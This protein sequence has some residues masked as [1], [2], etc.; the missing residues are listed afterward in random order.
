MALILNRNFVCRWPRGC[1]LTIGNFD[2][3]HRGHQALLNHLR[4]ASAKRGLPVVA[5]LFEPQPNEW[6]T[7][8]SAP[9]R[10]TTLREKVN[11]LTR[12]GV[13]HVVCLRFNSRLA[14]LEATAFI[15]RLLIAQLN[16]KLLAIGDDFRFG[17]GRT[18]D[19]ALLQAASKIY[20]FSLLRTAAFC[21]DGQRISSTAVR[22]A[23]ADDNLVLAELLLGRPYSMSGRVIHGD[24][25]GRTLGFP[26]ANFR[27]R[28]RLPV[29]GVYAVAMTDSAGERWPGV[30][31]I[32]TRPTLGGLRQQI[33]VHLLDRN[34]DL[35]RHEIEVTLLKKI[36]QEHRFASLAALQRQIADD[37]GAARAFFTSTLQSHRPTGKKT[38]NE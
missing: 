23:L 24:K 29:Q 37:V 2:G 34:S 13:E 11:Y 1:A 33:E 8:E 25:I 14:Q 7:V 15:E 28:G 16:V 6:F 9:A 20:D 4:I 22:H 3:V 5:M 38:L 19:Y 30:A 27:R 32:G 12:A 10:L 26:T 21:E 36:R 35:Y 18:G 31:N 17:A